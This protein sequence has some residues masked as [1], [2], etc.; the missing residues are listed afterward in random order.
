M[1]DLIKLMEPSFGVVSIG[2]MNQL[3]HFLG[4]SGKVEIMMKVSEN[5]SFSF[6]LFI[7][8]KYRG[9]YWKCHTILTFIYFPLSSHV[10]L[11]YKLVASGADINVNTYSILLKNLLMAGNWRKYIEVT[12]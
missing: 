7:C 12:Y 8:T 5:L 2:L 1:I 11:F 4:K 6:Y 10:Q 3:L 9:I